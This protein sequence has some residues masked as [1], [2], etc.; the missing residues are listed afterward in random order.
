MARLVIILALACIGAGVLLTGPALGAD[1]SEVRALVERARMW[2]L[3]DRPD[4]AR[5]A[6]Q[7]LSMVAPGHPAG[8]AIRAELEL[9]AGAA[10]AARATLDQL[11]QADPQYPEIE[12]IET[13]LRLNGPDKAKLREARLLAKAGRTAQAIAGLRSLY[14]KGPPDG[15]L[16]LEYWQLVGATPEGW[17]AAHAALAG[18]ARQDP[19]YLPYRFAL[20]E[21]E[22]MP[23]PLN[24]QALS[25][26]IEMAR[27]PAYARQ[28]HAAWRRAVMRLEAEPATVPLLEDYLAI[29]PGD[30]AARERLE[31]VL[32]GVQ[33]QR[34]LAADPAFQAQ[35]R[36]LALLE[37]GE[38][39]AAEPLLERALA[40]RP[41]DVE[42]VGGMGMLRLRQ[43]RHAQAQTFFSRALQL[44]QANASKWRGLVRTAHVWSAIRA[45]EGALERG[46]AELAE[47]LARDALQVSANHADATLALARAQARQGLQAQAE[48]SY[49]AAL[50]AEPLKLSAFRG[51]VDLLA[52]RDQ[53]AAIEQV[54]AGL[55]AAQRT[56]FA[57]VLDSTR[58]ATLRAEAERLV[59]SGQPDDA[60]RSLERVVELAPDDAW[61][62]HSLARLHADRGEPEL[63][64]A[65]L[66]QLLQR[67]PDDAEALHASA[68]FLA[69]LDE[70]AAALASLARIQGPERSDAVTRLERRIEVRLRSK[71]ALALA[72][73]G[74]RAEASAL[75]L[76]ADALAQG[77]ADALL[78]V[79]RGWLELGEF[80][81]AGSVLDR[82]Q[83]KVGTSAAADNAAALASLRSTVLRA[84]ADRLL[85]DQQLAQASTLL[86]R[87]LA[88]TP[89]EPWLRYD[90]ALLYARQ[91][92]AA[93]GLALLAGAADQP[94]G[95]PRALHALALY[96]SQ[97]NDAPAALDTLERTA[98]QARSGAVLHTQRRLW[99]Q[100]QVQRAQAA[101]QAGDGAAARRVLADAEAAI[102]GDA[103]LSTTL[104]AAWVD[105]GDADQ[106]RRMLGEAAPDA[107]LR[108]AALLARLGA[109]ARASAL[110]DDIAASPALSADDRDALRDLRDTL[111]IDRAEQL[112]RTGQTDAALELLREHS[113]AAP[114]RP[115][116]EFAQA[117]VLRT[118]RRYPEALER[119]RQVLLLDAGF[120]DARWGMIDT[121][122]RNGETER[123]REAI[124][125]LLAANPGDARA[126]RVLGTLEQRHGHSG[127]A[128]RAL[129]SAAASDWA[130]R[131]A[132]GSTGELSR[133]ALAPGDGT[134]SPALAAVMAEPHSAAS[135]IGRWWPYRPL[136]QWLDLNGRW[137]SGALDWRFRSG[138]DGKSSL[139]MK[140]LPIE[141]RWPWLGGQGVVR[142]D[143]VRLD[144]GRLDL[145]DAR[146]ARDFG[147]V[148]L[149]PPGC[150][151]GS[152]AQ[153]A[154]GLALNVGYENDTLRLDLGSTP[155]GFP[156][157]RLVGG[158]RVKGE[159]GP[160]SYSLDAASRPL[161]SSLLSYA[162]TRDPRSGSIWGGVQATGLTLTL[163]RDDGGA[164]GAWTLLGRHRLSGTHVQSNDRQ[165]W[166]AGAYWRVL[167][168]EN[169]QLS[170]GVTGMAQRFAH[171]AG[172]FSFGHGGYYSPSSHR[173]VS[174]PLTFSERAA[175]F[176]YLLR[177]AVSRSR[178]RT[179]SAAFYP[180]DAALQASAVAQ[181]GTT[182]VDPQYAGGP[183][184]GRGHSLA[185]TLE[186]QWQPNLQVGVRLEIERSRDFEPNR[187]LFYVRCALDGAI[188]SPVA[189]PPKAVS[190]TSE[191]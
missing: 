148:L 106:A 105:L 77:D 78:G 116:I 28:A 61:S 150:A 37:R 127:A 87:A 135:E 157:Q 5:E 109:H 72:H 30:T 97:R 56:A 69:W 31:A 40:A 126:L 4:L 49:R 34:R 75:L 48:Q 188:A 55:S 186:Y 187:A 88:L 89:D 86:E 9:R 51:L 59:A 166:M 134:A 16:A 144:A 17:A 140:E 10:D 52:E 95:D 15:E 118:A 45:S 3:R 179:D 141:L 82:I 162:G 67:R 57:Q 6:L 46:D 119:Y 129:Q 62:R 139:D 146:N 11:R 63:G 44:D 181:A 143:W 94:Q 191:L 7:R 115:R 8:F 125:P 14:P 22:L 83:T 177:A 99:M 133:L 175:R 176:S 13:L 68:L 18:L 27:L 131:A 183:G 107:R 156:V 113:E 161:T 1:T 64:R 93:R 164:L 35:R 108:H 71:R 155:L 41:D 149:C 184:S 47:R 136:A 170:V 163:S 53:Q 128:I 38:L 172:E 151:G 74:E 91:G 98:L 58:V 80:D 24:K 96:Q 173:S 130:A 190:P 33:A 114:A 84:E 138:S 103:A 12:R 117:Q 111:A 160:L 73:R 159:M 23:A 180:T 102:E 92:D 189:L 43:G 185:A 145:A 39:G 153:T 50:R 21:H 60:M 168:R 167:N 152:V 81:H 104:A 147:Q 158:V 25:K 32:A 79:A 122:E 120:E 123:A 65:L 121:L 169:R 42:I 85:A 20:A 110:L 171:N 137:L 174:L 142:A 19:E 36:G 66:D 90:L 29:A 154:N 178:S 26:V 124:D 2:V 165:Q 132:A 112:A 70:D 101:A 182:G 100:V 76:E 54:L